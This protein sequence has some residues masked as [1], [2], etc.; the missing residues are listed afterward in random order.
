MMDTCTCYKKEI[1]Y[2]EVNNIVNVIYSI[3]FISINPAIEKSKTLTVYLD[4][5]KTV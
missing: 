3:N 2:G 4:I 5:S 1:L